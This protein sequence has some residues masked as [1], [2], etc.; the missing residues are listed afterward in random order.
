MNTNSQ[1]LWETLKNSSQ[2][3]QGWNSW[4]NKHGVDG[5]L[6]DETDSVSF[7][8]NE[9]KKAIVVQYEPNDSHPVSVWVS[10]FGED[11]AETIEQLVLVYSDSKKAQKIFPNLV[12]KW[13]SPL[14]TVEKMSSI[15]KQVVNN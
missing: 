14:V 1:K 5:S 8:D 11:P 3:L 6:I 13:V 7:V 4:L 9:Q 15:I 10:T 12:D 2:I